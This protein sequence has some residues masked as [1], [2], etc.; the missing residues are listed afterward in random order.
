MSTYPIEFKDLED[1]N[2]KLEQ[3]NKDLVTENKLLRLSINDHQRVLDK[4]LEEAK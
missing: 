1:K 3:R 2:K 4:V